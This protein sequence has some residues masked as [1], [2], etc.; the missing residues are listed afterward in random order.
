MAMTKLR[1]TDLP[2]QSDLTTNPSDVWKNVSKSSE[3]PA[4]L[5]LIAEGNK[6]RRK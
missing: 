6:L 3:V 2:M 5:T 1:F 4:S